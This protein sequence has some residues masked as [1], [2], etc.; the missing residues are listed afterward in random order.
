MRQQ[1]NRLLRERFELEQCIRWQAAAEQ[2]PA[3][4]L[5][6]EGVRRPD[7]STVTDMPAP[8]CRYLAASMQLPGAVQRNAAGTG[9]RSP[10][11]HVQPSSLAGHVA[12]S[13]G[14]TERAA[15]GRPPPRSLSASSLDSAASSQASSR[16]RVQAGT[17]VE[18]AIQSRV[19]AVV[20]AGGSWGSRQ[21]PSG[22]A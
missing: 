19:A 16:G 3:L 9:T 10:V 2:L 21:M 8:D 17:A 6:Q 5:W 4:P 13:G 18:A 15:P 22:N 7:F 20:A 12:G 1:C 14:S 11:S